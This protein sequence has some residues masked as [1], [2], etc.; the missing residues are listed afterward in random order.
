MAHRGRFV[1]AS[2]RDRST[3]LRRAH[4]R[5]ERRAPK[6]DVSQRTWTRG[7][8]YPPRYFRISS[9]VDLALWSFRVCSK[10]RQAAC[11]QRFGATADA[12]A[13]ASGVSPF[14]AS[15]ILT[16]HALLPP[17]ADPL[18]D[19]KEEVVQRWWSGSVDLGAVVSA[20][21]RR[22]RAT[23]EL[24]SPRT[25]KGVLEVRGACRRLPSSSV[26]DPPSRPR[27]SDAS[28]S[29]PSIPKSG[30]SHDLELLLSLALR[31]LARLAV[32]AKNVPR[33]SLFAKDLQL[34]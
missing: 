1:R 26:R 22:A 24:T 8:V 30:T 19:L 20:S 32:V 9:V 4:C 11:G 33:D 31:R 17:S 7:C 34:G 29:R 14:P 27:A 3:P 28:R 16:Q 21:R 25:Q 23:L 13:G 12:S 2:S 6:K 18:G 15:W 5:C 10:G